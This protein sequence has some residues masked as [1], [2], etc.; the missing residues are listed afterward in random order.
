M[1]KE[2]V[3]EF[4]NDTLIQF[5]MKQLS[6]NSLSKKTEDFLNLV[7][8]P[9]KCDFLNDLSLNFYDGFERITINDSDYIVI[10]DDYGTKLCIEG[11]SDK[12]VSVNIEENMNIRFINSNLEF[13]LE[14]LQIFFTKKPEL[15]GVDDLKAVEIVNSIKDSFNKIDPVALNN[16][17][18]W[19]TL[20]LE[21]IEQGLL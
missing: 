5:N 9:V 3:M 4:W 17:D 21:Q 7:G 18:N 2:N 6:N 19:W 14:F 16:E 8:L 15:I 11:E 13:F 12:I 1:D 10:G 20:I